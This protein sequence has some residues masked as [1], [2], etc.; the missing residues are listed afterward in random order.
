LSV[1][2]KVRY[3]N[4]SFW[5]SLIFVLPILLWLAAGWSFFNVITP[6]QAAPLAQIPIYTPTPRPDGRIIYIVQ[7]NDT[8][9]G[10]SLLTGVP[11]DKLRG[12]N[13]LTGD[14]IYEGQEL[15]L[16]LGGPAEVTP[17]AGPTP[18]PTPI[19]PTPSPKPGQGTLCI[20]LFNDLNG[21]SIRQTDEDSIP[22]GAISFGNST[23]SVSESVK[24][25]IGTD[26]QCF[27]NLPE[28]IYT[29]SVAAP[30]GYNPT[31]T[32]TYELSLAAG[33]ITYI[34]FGAQA[35]SQTEAE[36]PAIPAREGGRSPLLGIIGGVLL[37]GG[38]IVAI[39]ASRTLRSH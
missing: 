22:D 38:I 7:P 25:G 5:V 35:N 4:K 27:E 1:E 17:T 23:G 16:G 32:N 2:K 18:T 28:G 29:L 15:L 9:L 24:T 31:T 34:N 12:L 3:K 13:N 33:D 37:L 6:A 26:P 19:L 10:I 39:L 8:L 36:S 20:L 14:T 11:L 21:D 30:E